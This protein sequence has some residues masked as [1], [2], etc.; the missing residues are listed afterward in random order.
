[1]KGPIDFG[2]SP[3]SVKPEHR[4]PSGAA[5]PG[6]SFHKILTNNSLYYSF[7]IESKNLVEGPI[8]FGRPPHRSP[9]GAVVPGK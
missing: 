1:V 5:A 6:K 2:R 3:H 8:D 9:S 4:P 7:D